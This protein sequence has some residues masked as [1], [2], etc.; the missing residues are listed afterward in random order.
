MIRAFMRC[1]GTFIVA[2]AVINFLVATGV[3]FY[4]V[5]YRPVGGVALMFVVEVLISWVFSVIGNLAVHWGRD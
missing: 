2:V 3:A 4:T 1:F 5:W